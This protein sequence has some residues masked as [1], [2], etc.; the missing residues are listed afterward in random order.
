M[1]KKRLLVGLFVIMIL[2]CFLV[3]KSLLNNNMLRQFQLEGYIIDYPKDITITY[4]ES[5]D[6]KLIV[7]M[8]YSSQSSMRF[9]LNKDI[10]NSEEGIIQPENSIDFEC[11]NKKLYFNRF[12]DSHFLRFYEYISNEELS[13]YPN[14][15]SELFPVLP[16]KYKGQGNYFIARFD[17][18]GYTE[19][20]VYFRN[21]KNDSDIELL[22]QDFCE[23]YS[24]QREITK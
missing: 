17:F 4:Q 23:I 13:K 2:V 22:S 19:S 11:L 16:K 7:D 21:M 20:S 1:K 9:A 18:M 14:R 15:G 12:N 10:Q 6:D 24:S 8:Q 5:G 3:I